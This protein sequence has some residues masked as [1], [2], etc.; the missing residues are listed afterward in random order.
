MP[1]TKNGVNILDRD[2]TAAILRE[3]PIEG[4]R[5]SDWI[6]KQ[7]GDF[8]DGFERTITQGVQNGDTSEQLRDRIDEVFKTGGKRAATLARTSVTHMNAQAQL[9]TY[10]NNED[11]VSGYFLDVTFD[12]RT[13][14]ICRQWDP[15]KK[16]KF[17]DPKRPIPPF[18]FNCRTKIR[19]AIEFD[20]LG[21]DEIP[22]KKPAVGAKNV[23]TGA[24]QRKTVPI[25]QDYDT[26]LRSQPQKFQEEVLGKER[27]RLWRDK[28]VSLSDMVRSDGKQ[29][30]LKE[31]EEFI[32]K[33]ETKAVKPKA[34]KPKP[35]V[36]ETPKRIEPPLSKE[37]AKAESKKPPSPKEFKDFS[38]SVDATPKQKVKSR[39]GMDKWGKQNFEPAKTAFTQK[40]YD[41]V[42]EYKRDGYVDVNNYLRKGTKG[43]PKQ[44]EDTKRI[45]NELDAV[46]NKSVLP[47]DVTVFRGL[48]NDDF[49]KNAVGK[50]FEENGFMS[51]TLDRETASAGFTGDKGALLEIK[52]PKG[53]NGSWLDDSG[54]RKDTGL[55]EW[56][57]LLKRDTK[58]K[59][60]GK[61]KVGK[62]TKYI[63]EVIS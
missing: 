26:F 38:A 15:G 40:E 7:K 9:K 31:L 30:N 13:S 16:Y 20:D 5:F 28:K 43:S 21:A 1:K 41:S 32:T 4:F 52:V 60:V 50:V 53:Y 12:N 36:E 61:E 35:V 46:M 51:T 37:K 33:K 22:L 34:K 44:F 24:R 42:I 56:E 3:I 55:K 27:A 29:L 25:E 17:D 54:I 19:P 2:E 49:G 63:A 62:L 58:Y 23:Q 18:H 47:D 6:K 45:V 48:A 59:I 57:I 39:K 11:F 14:A 10:E 8:L